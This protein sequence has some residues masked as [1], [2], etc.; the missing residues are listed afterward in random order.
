MMKRHDKRRRGVG[1]PVQVYLDSA[2]RARLER[3]TAQ[4]DATK[5]DVLRQGL[6]ALERQLT[7]PAAHPALRII[8][9]AAGYPRRSSAGYDV[10]REHDRF[11]GGERASVPGSRRA[12]RRVVPELFVDTSGWFPLADPEDPA[13]P[14]VARALHEAVQR[15]QRIVTTNLVVA[16]THALLLHRI[17]RAAA[18]AF[19]REVGREPHVVLTSTPDHET[20][21]QRDWLERYDDQDF[22]FTDA[23]SFTVMTERGIRDALAVD[24]HFTV[25]GFVVVPAE[26]C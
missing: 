11:P 9:I 4:L 25:A 21:A 23:V 10:A 19:L 22:S 14:A 5:S 16:E 20:R 13:H 3:L 2:E 18:L 17:H 6:G 8:G 1:E 15:G 24:R 12:R 7:D 26:A